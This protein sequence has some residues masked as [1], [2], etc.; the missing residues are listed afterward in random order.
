MLSI[1]RGR[2]WDCYLTVL[3]YE[4]GPAA[5]LTKYLAEGAQVRSQIRLSATPFTLVSD[6]G[7]SLLGDTAAVVRLY[8]SR[9]QTALLKLGTYRIDVLATDA[10]G[11]DEQLLPTQPLTVTED[12]THVDAGEV[13]EADLPP[14]IPD[15]VAEFETALSD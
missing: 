6:V 8:L 9:R 4:D 10:D 11:Y 1:T 13:T 15:F 3:D 12:P 14:T 5:D 7:V 2:T